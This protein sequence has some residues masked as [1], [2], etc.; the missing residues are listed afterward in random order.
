MGSSRHRR[1]KPVILVPDE[2]LKTQMDSDNMTTEHTDSVKSDPSEHETQLGSKRRNT[3]QHDFTEPISEALHE[4]S[5]DIANKS[6][7]V[8]GVILPPSTVEMEVSANASQTPPEPHEEDMHG[9]NKAEKLGI[10]GSHEFTGEQWRELS[11]YRVVTQ[12][13]MSDESGQET[14]PQVSS[15]VNDNRIQ[16]SQGSGE[17]SHFLEDV[18]SSIEKEH[19]VKEEVNPLVTQSETPIQSM[20]LLDPLLIE[21]HNQEK[22]QQEAEL[23]T[24][25]PCTPHESHGTTGICVESQPLLTIQ[26][27]F[28]PSNNQERLYKMV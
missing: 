12:M 18:Q 19:E 26:N 28:N 4:T 21:V 16:V 1:D 11:D 24:D 17:E 3:R 13:G 27:T 20:E 23:M 6:E 22:P 10:S 2:T 15:P 8:T 7:N 14:K 5:V 9:N 25:T